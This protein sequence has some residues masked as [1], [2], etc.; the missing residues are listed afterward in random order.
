VIIYSISIQMEVPEMAE[1]WVTM[2]E[3][4]KELKITTSKVSR[5]AASGVIEVREGAVD[6]RQKYVDVESIR[7][8]LET[9]YRPE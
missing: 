2:K 8:L 7:K 6:R 4:A 9:G 1:R 5:L 3:A